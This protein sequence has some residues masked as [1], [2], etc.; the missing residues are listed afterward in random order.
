MT[1]ET[2]PQMRETI[3][4]LTKDLKSTGLARD[5]A[6]AKVRGLTGENFAR[7]VDFAPKA[8]A[9]YA[10]NTEGDLTVEGF[11]AFASDLGLAATVEAKSKEAEEESA[12]E[13]EK[14]TEATG[15]ADL[16]KMARGGSSNEEG[17]AGSATEELMTRAEWT[18]LSRTDPIAAREA[19]AKG[20][21]LLS[22]DNP[23]MPGGSQQEG[24]PFIRGQQR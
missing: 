2:I 13:E 22:K 6:E 16:A 17:G 19:L 9:M 4:R 18:S 3:D 1:E 20:K 12:S 8:G 11:E 14:A 15:S 24:N 5:K 10:A 7:E 21:V 23:Y